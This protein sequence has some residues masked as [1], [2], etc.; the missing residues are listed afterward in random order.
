M[1]AVQLIKFGAPQEALQYT[2]LPDPTPGPGE[3]LVKIE[4]AGVCGRDLVVRKGA[5]PHVK[6]P[7][8]PGHEGVGKV[9]DVGAGV[10]RDLI[11][12]RV[13]LSAIYDGTCDY[14]RRGFENLCRNAELLGEMRN[15]TYGEYVVIPAK[16]AHPFHGVDPKAAVLATCPISTAVYVLKHIDVERKKVLVVGAGGTGIYIAQLAKVRGAEVYVSTRS[17][18]KASV[19]KELGLGVAT[20]GEKDFDVVIDT[21]G[22]P[23]LE[24]SLKLAKRAGAVVVIGNVTGEKALLSPALVILR[25]LRVIGS[26]A[27]R[28]WDI[29][30][31]LDLLKRGLIKPLYVEYKLQDAAKAHE[32][33]ERG[34]VMG[35][36]VLLP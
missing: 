19:L 13:F 8:I 12:M 30:E 32:D 15:G 23:T 21:V 6:P 3:V 26:M 10:E 28:P 20:E 4:A 27:F 31:A 25:Q 16:F 18:E 29:Y 22:A 11:G 7:I 24:R 36:A 14:C 34:R 17:P 1:R 35:R 9:I 5:F 2:E 33:M